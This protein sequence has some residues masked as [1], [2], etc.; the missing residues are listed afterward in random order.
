MRVPNQQLVV[1]SLRA[2][3]QSGDAAE[4][5]GAVDP[6]AR[7]ALERHGREAAACGAGGGG[8]SPHPAEQPREAAAVAVVVG[9]DGKAAGG[10]QR[11]VR[12]V[13]EWRGEERAG[14]VGE[15]V[16]RGVVREEATSRCESESMGVMI[17]EE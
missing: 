3:E 17:R 13:E 4:D 7:A 14:E 2:N 16:L 1:T 8:A 15:R 11:A 5:A 9:E 6:L 12:G 10:T